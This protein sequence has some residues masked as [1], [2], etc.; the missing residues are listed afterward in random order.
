M[1]RASWSLK[2]MK[3]IDK[4]YSKKNKRLGELKNK[5]E[6]AEEQNAKLVSDVK[7]VQDN[8]REVREANSTLL[9]ERAEIHSEYLKYKRSS[10]D[11][12]GKLKAEQQGRA[13]DI[14][15]LTKD[16]IEMFS[17]GY[18][19][20]KYNLFKEYRDKKTESWDVDDF[21]MDFE[22]EEKL[23]KELREAG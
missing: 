11:F 2:L 17:K 14:A 22:E 3:T 21:I 9:F 15:K 13:E 1:M 19:K 20:C 5:L 18:N 12:E 4:T 7:I 16:C 6:L 10:E 8:E 23:E